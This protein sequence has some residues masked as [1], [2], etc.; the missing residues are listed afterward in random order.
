[1]NQNMNQQNFNQ[2]PQTNMQQP[3]M[4]QMPQQQMNQNYNMNP[5]PQYYREEPKNDKKGSNGGVILFLLL[6]VIGL[7][8]YIAYDKFFAKKDTKEDT[9]EKEEEKKEDKQ[10]EKEEQK[11]TVQCDTCTKFINLGVAYDGN[12]FNEVTGKIVLGNRV[13]DV[14]FTEESNHD[15]IYVDNKAIING[16]MNEFFTRL[17]VIRDEVIMIQA[18]G[19]DVGSNSYYFFD[20]NLNPINV[21]MT[22]DSQYPTAMRQSGVDNSITVDGDTVRIIGSRAYH[23]KSIRIEG[24]GYLP[25]CDSNYDGS[26]DGELISAEYEMKYLGNNQFSSFTKVKELSFVGKDFCNN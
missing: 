24:N 3:N 4:N 5:Q 7:C 26:H 6:I 14:R 2:M 18:A 12:N 9:S 10:E 22:L 1:M 25:V 20:K 17:Y 21:N 8:G 11:E 23:G 15:S 19:S 16:K 13:V